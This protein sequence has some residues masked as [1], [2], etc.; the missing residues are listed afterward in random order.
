MSSTRLLVSDDAVLQVANSL[1]ERDRRILR[2]LYDHRVFTTEHLTEVP[3]S[4][5]TTARH[6]LTQLYRLRL[7]DRFRPRRWPSDCAPY[8]YVIGQIGAMVIT[9]ERDQD[10]DK[11]KWKADKALAI[12][13]SQRLD[14]LI[15]VN[16]FFVELM[17]HSCQHP[18]SAELL[19]WWSERRCAQAMGR[20]VHPDAYGVWEENGRVIEFLLEY[21]R[22]TESLER[23]AAKLKGY[24]HLEGQTG[25]RRWVLFSL[26]TERREAGVRRALAGADVPVATAPRTAGGPQDAVWLVLRPRRSEVRMCLTGL[27]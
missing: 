19:E 26:R 18:D 15:G 9:A 17:K 11:H 16:A 5:P 24:K 6:R 2:L 4:N 14:H 8:H 13:S 21:D 23:V 3:F 7:V 27:A 20:L 1:T 10:P 12:G 22:G 25:V